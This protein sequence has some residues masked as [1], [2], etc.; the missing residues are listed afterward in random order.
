MVAETKKKDP[1]RGKAFHNRSI[2]VDFLGE[3]PRTRQVNNFT[4]L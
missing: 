2:F 3:K 4:T 1:Y